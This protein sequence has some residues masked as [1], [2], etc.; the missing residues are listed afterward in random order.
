MRALVW[1]LL[2]SGLVNES[3]EYPACVSAQWSH[4]LYDSIRPFLMQLDNDPV[5]LQQC[6]E[7]FKSWRLGIRFE[8]YWAFIAMTYENA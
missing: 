3:G 8:A 1:S 7:Q 5:E 6:L 2:S 4:E